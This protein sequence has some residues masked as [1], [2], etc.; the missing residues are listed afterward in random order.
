VIIS[1]NVAPA[2]MLTNAALLLAAN[3]NLD[4]V[5]FND[6]PIP[7]CKIINYGQYMYQQKKNKA[8]AK[9]NSVQSKQKEITLSPAIDDNDLQHKIDKAKEFLA[10]GDTVKFNMRFRGRQQA[11]PNI[12]EQKLKYVLGHLN[13]VATITKDSSKLMWMIV[14]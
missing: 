10:N 1:A 3:Q 2:I 12:G 9:K 6:A 4:L 14:R 13:K 5:Q 11:H 8:R 7:L